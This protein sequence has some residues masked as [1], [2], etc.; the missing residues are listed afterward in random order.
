MPDGSV[1]TS[2]H[3]KRVRLAGE[4]QGLAPSE[5]QTWYGKYAPPVDLDAIHADLNS[6]GSVR[7]VVECGHC[8]AKLEIG[9]DGTRHCSLC[10]LTI[11][12]YH[13]EEG[14]H[15]DDEVDPADERA[16]IDLADY[17]DSLARMFPEPAA[18]VEVDVVDPE[19]VPCPLGNCSAVVGQRCRSVGGDYRQ[20]H[21][22]PRVTAAIVAAVAC[23]QCHA[24]PGQP[25]MT[26]KGTSMKRIHA[27]RRAGSVPVEIGPEPVDLQP[28][29][30]YGEREPGNPEPFE[31]WC[32]KIHCGDILNVL[33]VMPDKSVD[34][35]IT[36]PPYNA[37]E[38]AG[39][40]WRN[41]VGKW[42]RAPLLKGGYDTHSDRMHPAD[43]LR[44]QQD[45]LR[46]MMRVLK[47]DGA[48]LYNHRPRVQVDRYED[49]ARDIL[50]ESVLDEYGFALRQVILWDRGSGFN[51]NAGYFLPAYEEL[52]LVAKPGRFRHKGLGSVQNVW[53]V[54]PD[55]KRG[56]PALPVDLVRIPLATIR[57]SFGDDYQPVVLDPFVGS[58]SVAVAAALEDWRYIGIDIS[59]EYC[60]QAR[61][62]VANAEAELLAAWETHLEELAED[63]GLQV[64]Y[65]SVETPVDTPPMEVDTPSGDEDTGLQVGYQSVETPVDTP[66]MEVDTPS[67][68]EDTGLQVGYQS[69]ETPVDTPPMEV[70]TPS[71]DEDTGLQVGYQSVE[72]PVDTPPLAERAVKVLAYLEAKGNELGGHAPVL[73]QADMIAELGMPKNTLQRALADLQYG[74]L[75][76]IGETSQGRRGARAYYLAGQHPIPIIAPRN[77]AAIRARPGS[78]VTNG[79]STPAG[80]DIE[81]L[82]PDDQGDLYLSGPAGRRIIQNSSQAATPAEPE[83]PAPPDV[84]PCH[85][86]GPGS[87]VESKL[88][89]RVGLTEVYH[90]A[91]QNSTCSYVYDAVSQTDIVVPG[92]DQWSI[93]DLAACIR[94]VRAW[95]AYRAGGASDVQATGRVWVSTEDDPG[96]PPEFEVGNSRQ[97]NDPLTK[98]YDDYEEW[99]R[100]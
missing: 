17:H 68:D 54:Q 55:R 31:W 21:H 73:K 12:D 61:N 14:F 18:V 88:L 29:T 8:A 95:Q 60:R 100:G 37:L 64:G 94:R 82:S 59:E 92:T 52:F 89:T 32:D 51:H 26:G 28:A 77:P 39:G 33:R 4:S 49:H 56:L 22:A 90:C 62:R 15:A 6:L 2:P 24:M 87:M 3:N 38:T 75:L 84:P 50:T 43:Y 58:G 71:G 76:T 1:R 46:E 67:G 47:D 25:C 97:E 81:I 70:D 27:V 44:W 7:V 16:D 96:V 48:I 65:Q 13:D 83:R 99:Q 63:V 78:G 34:L 79:V 5:W 98:Y 35:I 69:V 36:S 45:C 40:G 20:K 10:G 85:L 72:T 23:S 74:G 53:R 57:P 91:G 19:S 9:K 41:G 66:P 42:P 86:C 93:P 80:P 11:C 30:L